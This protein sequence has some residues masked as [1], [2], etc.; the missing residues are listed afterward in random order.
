VPD[1]SNWVTDEILNVDYL[2]LNNEDDRRF[3]DWLI[4]LKDRLIDLRPWRKR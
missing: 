1:D 3:R 4:G 2:I